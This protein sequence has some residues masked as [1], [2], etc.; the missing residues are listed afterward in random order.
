MGLAFS[1]V[2]SHKSTDSVGRA[3]RVVIKEESDET[4]TKEHLMYKKQQD[5][6]YFLGYLTWYN[7]E[8]GLFRTLY[9]FFFWQF[10]Q[11]SWFDSWRNVGSAL[12]YFL[13]RK[14]ALARMG[15]D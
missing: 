3:I 12:G 15:L 8:K 10:A 11:M 4:P 14:F 2:T 5:A 7:T 13:V 6:K 1:D 9:D